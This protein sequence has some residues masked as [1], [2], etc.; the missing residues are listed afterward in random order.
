M[1]ITICGHRKAAE[2]LAETP[3]Q[4]D[5]IFIS[6]PDAKFAVEGSARIAGL[7]RECCEI[8]FNDIAYP[9]GSLEHPEPHHVQKALDFAKGKD[10]LIVACQAGISR[11][12][13]IAFVI[14]AAEV[15]LLEAF[16]ILN[17][18]VHQ[19]NSLVIKHGAKLLGEQD[20]MAMM[21]KWK[22]ES[23][24]AQWDGPFQL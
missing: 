11:S 15:G 7:A 13:A 4:R 21:D 1:K 12:S 14:Q 5:I 2:I 24:A 16:K 20:M 19:P 6:S 17:P 9:M 22:N 3:N 18:L 8:L 10:N 23:E